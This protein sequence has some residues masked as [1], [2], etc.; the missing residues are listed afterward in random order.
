MGKRLITQRRGRGGPKYRAPSHRFKSNAK[1]P[2]HRGAYKDKIGGQV[3]DIIHDPGRTAPIAKVLLENFE[4][5]RIIAFDGVKVGQ[6][7]EIG[8]NAKPSEGN[9]LPIGKMGEGTLAYNLEINPGDGGKLV[10]S[11]GSSSYVV[12]HERDQGVTYIRLPSKKTIAINSKSRATIGKVS[13][14]GR[15][16]KPMAHA[17]QA[18]YAHKARNKL[19]P[20]VCGNAMN[21]VDHPH[22]GGRNPHGRG[23]VSRNAPPGAKVGHIAPKR[24]GRR[25]RG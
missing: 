9:I 6:W 24:T 22:G 4:E 10:R 16:E 17:G 12:S 25:K 11:A 5:I 14:G 19:Y 1:Y 8:E 7:I 21:A 13:G 18:Y 2:P 23:P 20:R 3:I 15:K